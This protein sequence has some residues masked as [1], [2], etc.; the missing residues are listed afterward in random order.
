[1]FTS[2]H[3]SFF[4]PVVHRRLLALAAKLE[5]L[6][7]LRKLALSGD[8]Q[9]PGADLFTTTALRVVHDFLVQPLFDDF[10]GQVIPGGRHPLHPTSTWGAVHVPTGS[11]LLAHLSEKVPAD[12]RIFLST[13]PHNMGPAVYESFRHELQR[14]LLVNVARLY[15]PSCISC[16][17]K[18]PCHNVMP[19]NYYL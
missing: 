5:S 9:L 16:D 13:L 1:M 18:L 19:I 3:L 2:F 14:D 12:L 10:A 17:N 6:E 8:L 11:A 15:M 4:F 7:V